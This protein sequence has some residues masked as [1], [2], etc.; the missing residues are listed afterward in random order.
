MPVKIGKHAPSSS[1]GHSVKSSSNLSDSPICSD[2][3]LTS[4]IWS[5]SDPSL[6]FQER[7]SVEAFVILNRLNRLMIPA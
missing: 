5:R 6:K 3:I 4:T 2:V 7:F 1:S